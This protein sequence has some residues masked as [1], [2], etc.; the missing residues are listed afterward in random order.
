MNQRRSDQWFEIRLN[1]KGLDALGGK[2]RHRVPI[3]STMSGSPQAIVRTVN[4]RIN[5]QSFTG[6]W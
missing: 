1:D 5:A 4:A 2:K 3:D 6:G